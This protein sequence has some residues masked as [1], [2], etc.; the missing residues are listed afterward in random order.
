VACK[1]IFGVFIMLGI[2][3]QMISAGAAGIPGIPGSP[4]AQIGDIIISGEDVL[5]DSDGNPQ[6]NLLLCD[7]ST[8][9]SLLYPT[10]FQVL[11]ND[12][13]PNIPDETGSPFPYKIV[14]D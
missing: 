6:Y 10:L 7:G 8:F 13:L 5:D 12:V 1:R 14:A 2:N 11:G 4:F 3:K 9:D